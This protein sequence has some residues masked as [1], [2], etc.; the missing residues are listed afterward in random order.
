MSKIDEGGPVYPQYRKQIGENVYELGPEGGITRRDL[1]AGLAMQ[2]MLSNDDWD[3][4][5]PDYSTE[6][7]YRFADALI[8]EGRKEGE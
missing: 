7:A 8:A 6:R 2:G 5:V 3:W 1:L 4:K